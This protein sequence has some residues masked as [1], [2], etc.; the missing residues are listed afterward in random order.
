MLT[1]R[2]AVYGLYGAYRLAWLDPTG[3]SFLDRT[4]A[5]ALRSFAVF[6]FV[7]PA[8]ALLLLMRGDVT[9]PDLSVELVAQLL[10]YVVA[11]LAYLLLCWHLT[12][13]IAR[14]N[15][16]ADFVVAY[17]WSGVLQIGLY[18][19]V[20]VIASAGWLP[21]GAA[22]GLAFLAT[23]ATAIYQWFVTKTALNVTGPTA[24]GFVALDL[25]V[26]L[27]IRGFSGSLVAPPGAD[28]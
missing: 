16:F 17:N 20:Q 26:S 4:G 12:E 22:A 8:Y 6:I 1:L 10:S 2:E 25:L 11:W 28:A 27:V 18:L 13:R 21:P 23:V 24:I 14:Q 19:P 7:L 3:L 9:G 15:R 5:G